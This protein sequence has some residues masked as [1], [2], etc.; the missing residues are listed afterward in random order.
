MTAHR[1]ALT[2]LAAGLAVSLAGVAFGQT[3]GDFILRIAPGAD[4]NA[5][6]ARYNAE[7]VAQIPE[8]NLFRVRPGPALPGELVSFF[9]E[10]DPDVEASEPD[11]IAEVVSG[12]TQSF[13]FRMN[14]EY[15]NQSAVA[16]LDITPGLPDGVGVTVAILDTG[17][18]PNSAIS[19]AILPG[20][21][22]VDSTEDTSD[23]G[24]GVDSNF[25]G[26]IDE[27]NGHGTFIAGLV[28]LA[29]PHCNLLPVKV[30][31]SD[32]QG[33]VYTVTAGIYYAVDHGAQVIN[34]SLSLPTPSAL[35]AEAIQH[36]RASGVVVVASVGNDGSSLPVYPAAEPGVIAVAATTLADDKAWFSDYGHHVSIC[37]P[38][39]GVVSTLPNDMFGVGSGASFATAWVSG[40]AAVLKSS[41]FPDPTPD[42]VARR[43]K[44]AAMNVQAT[45]IDYPGL[46]GSGRIS[47]GNLFS[48]SRFGQA[49]FE[50]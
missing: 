18:S 15:F 1:P 25:N 17:I 40:A 23:I 37:A 9:I 28:S 44:T 24:P 10:G 50:K 32:G 48:N 36:A 6:C 20:H 4:I 22:F 38:G 43:I 8:R 33:S 14:A 49:Q 41:P 39:D 42:R 26:V 16:L 46:L 11:H 30:L 34:L 31:D 45:M 13:F 2:R 27:M 35:V 7:V 29:A 12:H 19:A 5:V 47:I 21:N 3:T